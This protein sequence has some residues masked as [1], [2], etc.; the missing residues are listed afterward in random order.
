LTNYAQGINDADENL[1]K[2]LE[3]LKTRKKHTVVLFFWDHL[4]NLWDNNI[5]YTETK[6]INEKEEK[7][8]N[9]DNLENM[10]SPDFLIWSNKWEFENK[11]LWYIWSSYLWNYVLD[12][13][14]IWNKWNYFDYISEEFKCLQA[15]S[16]VL[17]T[18]KETW[19]IRNKDRTSCLDY[20]K[21]HALLQYDT[22]FGKNYIQND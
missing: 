17:S 19:V 3:Y 7:N 21:N 18:T 5:W 4:P 11:D 6:Y 16:P 13:S 14:G 1:W 10:Y 15:N 20:D 22:L 9:R 8:W 2:L 12:L